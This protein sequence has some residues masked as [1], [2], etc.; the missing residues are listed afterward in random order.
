MAMDIRIRAVQMAILKNYQPTLVIFNFSP[1]EDCV[2][3][4]TTGLY[5]ASQ[6][7]CNQAVFVPTKQ[8]RFTK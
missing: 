1:S 2:N 7:N 5:Y 3:C 8:E 6:D 4:P